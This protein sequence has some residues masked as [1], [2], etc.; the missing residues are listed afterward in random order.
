VA[1]IRVKQGLEKLSN[2]LDKL[3]KQINQYSGIDEKEAMFVDNVATQMTVQLAAIAG[4]ART[5][6]GNKSGGKLV[7]KVRKALGF[8]YP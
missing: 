8:T 5:V 6:M 7:E 4:L 1:N 2:E 3:A